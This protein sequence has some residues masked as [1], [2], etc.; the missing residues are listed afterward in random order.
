ME[1]TKRVKNSKESKNLIQNFFAL[2]ILQI[3]GYVFPII[4]LPYLARVIGVEKFG[5]I[6]FAT[7]VIVYMQAIVDYGFVFSAVR[8]IARCRTDRQAISVI[9]SRVMWA[10]FCLVGLA[11]VLLCILIL[12]IPKFQSMKAVLL[13]SFLIVPGHAMFPDWMFQA[14][15]KMKY[16][17]LFNVLVKLIFTIAVF[18]FIKE[19]SDYLFQPIFNAFGYIVSGIASMYVIRRFGIRLQWV[20]F[21]EV[22]VAVRDNTNLFI[23]QFV[24]NLYNSLSVVVLGFFYGSAANGIFDAGNKFNNIC[25]NLIQ[26]TSRTFFPF[27]SRK[28]EKHYV[29]V[30]INIGLSLTMGILLFTFA[31][32]IIHTFFTPKFEAAVAVLR[33]LSISLVFLAM[34]NVYG[35]NFLIIKGYEKEIRSI[36]IIASLTGFVLAFPLIYCYSYMGAAIVITLSRGIIGL[37]SYIKARQIKT[38]DC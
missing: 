27:L 10:R 9:Y 37:L 28:I 21:K 32:W 7:A 23:N 33:I 11:F 17:T 34:S 25:T 8:D 14:L 5:E 3:A 4:T 24:P 18:M 16:I 1:W 15:E 13:L 2:S 36:T 30:W 22:F 29:I 20:R 12:L 19:P 35:T 38:S 31:P 6:A 26:V